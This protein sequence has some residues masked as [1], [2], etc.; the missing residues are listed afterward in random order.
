MH[1]WGLSTQALA[2]RMICFALCCNLPVS[3]MIALDMKT[4]V[5]WCGYK[6]SRILG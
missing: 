5:Q 6:G 1:A 3:A 2:L 4:L